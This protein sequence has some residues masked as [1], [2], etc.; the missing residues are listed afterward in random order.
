[1]IES[2]NIIKMWTYFHN[3]EKLFVTKTIYLFI[4]ILEEFLYYFFILSKMRIQILF[5]FLFLL[6]LITI[7]KVVTNTFTP[8]LFFSH[9]KFYYLGKMDYGI[10]LGNLTAKLYLN[11]ELENP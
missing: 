5:V 3:S 6:P 10:G 11:Q 2:K 7:S 8:G 9:N 1:M 4:K